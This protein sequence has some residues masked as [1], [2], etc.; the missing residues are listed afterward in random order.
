[1]TDVKTLDVSVVIPVYRSAETLAVLVDRL[2]VV[3]ARVCA[4]YG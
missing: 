4:S 3:M 1:M 2:L